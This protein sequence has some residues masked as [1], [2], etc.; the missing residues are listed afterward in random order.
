M[1]HEPMKPYAPNV[2]APGLPVAPSGGGRARIAWIGGLWLLASAGCVSRGEGGS[3][4]GGAGGGT[5]SGGA[6]GSPVATSGELHL[7]LVVHQWVSMEGIPTPP[8]D[9]ITTGCPVSLPIPTPHETVLATSGS[10]SLVTIEST[11]PTPWAVSLGKVRVG[12]QAEP[13][14]WLSNPWEP[15]EC[16][17]HASEDPLPWNEV[18]T[19]E[20]VGDADLPA[21]KLQAP[22]PAPFVATPDS[23]FTAGAPYGIGLAYGSAGLRVELS[24]A[25]L[26][27]SPRIVCAPSGE[28]SL[29]ID[30]ALTAEIAPVNDHVIVVVTRESEVSGMAGATPLRARVVHEESFS[31]VTIGQ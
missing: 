16:A 20:G 30:G 12:F 6:G 25:G 19:F 9:T 24:G 29:V 18:V 23:H 1:Q 11:L 7:A 3:L 27:S 26:E 31:P 22:A 13:A 8:P 10:C 28:E 15:G 17:S 14:Y 4:E 5:G 2:G 21:F